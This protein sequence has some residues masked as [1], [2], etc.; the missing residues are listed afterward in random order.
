[1]SREQFEQAMS[2]AIMSLPQDLKAMLRI[3]ED[4]DLEDEHRTLV[5]GA[6]V[7]VLSGANAIPGM[8]G[9]L[10]YVDDVIVLRLVLERLS[11]EAPDVMA[12]HKK[13]SPELLEPLEGQMETVREYLGDLLTV[14]DKATDQLP[15]LTH[16]GHSAVQCAREHEASTWLYEAVHAA[17]TTELDFDEAAVARA[18]KSVDQIKRPLQQRM[19]S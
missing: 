6:L 1:M 17:L 9:I 5:A 15:K 18:M 11:R 8:R 12:R 10:A 4:P 19:H 2:E 3:V 7:H 13:D 16:E 14:L